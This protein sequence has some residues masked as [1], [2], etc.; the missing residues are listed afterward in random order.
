M[1]GD[2]PC[3]APRA[4]QGNNS[5][6]ATGNVTSVEADFNDWL[7]DQGLLPSAFIELTYRCNQ[8]CVHC[9]NPGATH[10]LG[11]RAA[12]GT[13]KLTTRE[14]AALADL[15]DLASPS[16]FPAEKFRSE[17]ICWKFSRSKTVWFLLQSVH[18]WTVLGAPPQT[19][20]LALA[21]HLGRQYLFSRFQDAR[22]DH[23]S[24]G[25]ICENVETLRRVSTGVRATIKCP[26]M[27]HTVAGYKRVLDL[28][29]EVN[30]LPQFDLDIL[31]AWMAIVPVPSIK[32]RI[33]KPWPSSC[34]TPG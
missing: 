26:L 7:S 31:L 12:Q 13:D 20:L 6:T 17:A 28:C 3:P 16:R 18:Q 11:K 8:N 21:S 30:A 24:G 1:Q 9:F 2:N 4:D 29:D 27:R 15:A 32:S 34:V 19:H 33:R 23:W 22:C 5:G 14:V 10:G 25:L